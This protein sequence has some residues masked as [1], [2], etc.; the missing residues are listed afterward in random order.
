MNMDDF[1]VAGGD[2]HRF[3]SGTEQRRA[4]RQC[5]ARLLLGPLMLGE[6]EAGQLPAPGSLTATTAEDESILVPCP[7]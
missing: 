4:P 2:H 3:A 5:G 1:N 6:C 7:R